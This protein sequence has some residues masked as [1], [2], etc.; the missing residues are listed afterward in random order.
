MTKESPIPN[1]EAKEKPLD[2]EER[3]PITTLDSRRS[4]TAVATCR[5]GAGLVPAY[6]DLCIKDRAG[7]Q[8]NAESIEY[9]LDPR[10]RGDDG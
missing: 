9:Q 8:E 3:T 7:N 4:G 6:K 1:D 2:L 5:N 10:L